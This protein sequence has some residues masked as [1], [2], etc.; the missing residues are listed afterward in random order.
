MLR[1]DIVMVGVI[2]TGAIGFGLDRGF[3][4]LEHSLLPWK[5]RR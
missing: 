2:V 4:L 5:Y 1:L 3:R